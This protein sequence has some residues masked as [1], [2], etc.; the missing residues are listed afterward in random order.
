MGGSERAGPERAGPERDGLLASLLPRC[1]F[2]AP[3]TALR[4]GV[5]GGRDSLAL[6]ALAV[7]QGLEVTA[8][9]VDHGLRPGSAEEAGVVAA[10]AER[11]GAGFEARRVVVPPGPNLEE[12][13]REAR[14]VAL[15]PGAATGHTMDDQAETVLLRLLRGT[16]PD[17]LAGMTPGPE[18][19]LLGIRRAE[20]TALCRALGLGWLEDPSNADPRFRRNQVRQKLLPLCNELAGRDVVPLLARLADLAREDRALLAELA[21]TLDATDARALRAAPRPLARRAL[22]A[23][24][25]ADQPHPPDLASIERVL[26]VA[27]GLARATELPGGR[28]VA[29]RAGRLRLEEPE[30]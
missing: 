5:S 11:L 24:L 8:V 10:A 26:A 6:L 14:R 13:A 22:R 4:V 3:G 23:W 30:R 1:R 2:P 20:T 28:R 21:G 19:P 27:C 18:H 9:H 15:G 29:R 25:G 12:R 7:A 17:G 16:G